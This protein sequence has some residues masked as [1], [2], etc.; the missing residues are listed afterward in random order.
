[1]DFKLLGIGTFYSLIFLYALKNRFPEE[2]LLEI[3]SSFFNSDNILPAG[4]LHNSSL[5]HQANKRYNKCFYFAKSAI[6]T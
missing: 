4:T 5:T 1:V 6:T 3:V 2:L